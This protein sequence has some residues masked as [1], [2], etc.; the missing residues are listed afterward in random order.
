MSKVIESRQP[1]KKNQVIFVLFDELT[2]K[3][4][5]HNYRCSFL[6][7]IFNYFI[8]YVNLFEKT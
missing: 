7:I 4:S 5:I 8:F 1:F 3:L 2:F 6:D